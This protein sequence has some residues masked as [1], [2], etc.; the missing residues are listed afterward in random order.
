MALASAPEQTAEAIDP[1]LGLHLALEVA[2]GMAK[3]FRR[4]S[5]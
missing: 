1:R 2:F 4:V 3:G 5:A